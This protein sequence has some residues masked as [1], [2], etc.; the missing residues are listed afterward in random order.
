MGSDFCTQVLDIIKRNNGKILESALLEALK[1]RGILTTQRELRY[2]LLKLEITG[3]V[4][5]TSLDEER[6]IIEIVNSKES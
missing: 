2:A 6:K 1:N 5:V 3:Y 4:R